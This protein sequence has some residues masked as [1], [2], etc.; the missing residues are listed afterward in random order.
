MKTYRVQLMITAKHYTT[1]TVEADSEQ[2]AMAGAEEQAGN[3]ASFNRIPDDCVP[4]AT[5]FE[6]EQITQISEDEDE[7][8]GDD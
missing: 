2:E 6:I 8:Q 7:D 4:E 3:D 5:D 1:Y